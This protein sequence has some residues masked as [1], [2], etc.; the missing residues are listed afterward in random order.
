LATGEKWTEL[1][2][3]CKAASSQYS[4]LRNGLNFTMLSS[5]LFYS[6]DHHT[7][8]GDLDLKMSIEEL[9]P[10]PG[11]FLSFAPQFYLR[12]T[13]AG[14]KRNLPVI[15][16]GLVTQESLEKSIHPRDDKANIPISQL[17]EIVFFGF[18]HQMHTI[19]IR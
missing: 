8:F 1:E 9:T 14:E 5:R 18:T 19:S 2:E 4:M 7:F 6:N 10:E 13:L 17:P 15:E 11:G 3:K 12:R 16:F